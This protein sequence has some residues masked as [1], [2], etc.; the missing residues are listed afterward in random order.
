[1]E[2]TRAGARVTL[3]IPP[4]RCADGAQKQAAAASM[5][6]GPPAAFL[7]VDDEPSIRSALAIHLR[8]AGHHV[9][10]AESGREALEKLARK[11]YDAIFL[12]LRMPDLSGMELYAR[13]RTDDPAHASRVVFATGDVEAEG[14]RT[15]LR[16]SG[17]P[18]LAKPFQLQA[19]S[20][21]LQQV[22]RDA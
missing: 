10:A 22:A 18:F 14:A 9:D 21:L 1:M 8:R 7:L 13:L 19:V 2:G 4:P 15:F 20:E 12:D 5:P 3:A 16:A 11:R 6:H 17:R